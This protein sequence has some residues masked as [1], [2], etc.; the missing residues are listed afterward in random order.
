MVPAANPEIVVEA[1]FPVILPGFIVQFPNGKSFKTKLPVTKPQVGCVI[2][3]N[4]G[5]NGIIFTVKIAS[6]VVA[7]HDPLAA[8]V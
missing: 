2:V 1:V 4:V 6:E 7:G 3:P 8:T 5:G